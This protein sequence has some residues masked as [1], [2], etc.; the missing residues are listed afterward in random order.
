M[1][2][3]QDSFTRANANLPGITSDAWSWVDITST[4]SPGS[5]K[6]YSQMLARDPDQKTAV[7]YANKAFATNSQFF[8]FGSVGNFAV[9]TA[10]ANI[11]FRMN[12]DPA[13]SPTAYYHVTY[14]PKGSAAARLSVGK[15]GGDTITGQGIDL[16]FIA[17]DT[18]DLRATSVRVGA[19]QVLTVFVDGVQKLQLTDTTATLH[20]GKYFGIQSYANSA[21]E[22]ANG[23]SW[24]ADDF[25][26]G[27]TVAVGRYN[28]QQFDGT[29]AVPVSLEAIQDGTTKYTQSYVDYVVGE[30]DALYPNKYNAGYFN[31]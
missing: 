4:A 20:S 7:V 3:I 13:A 8:E 11:Q 24:E 29:N 21:R 28:M 25:K 27:D 10:T 23:N 18:F 26:A 2:R 19:T 15:V 17:T 6:I 30:P 1:T 14:V 9:G 16:S 12:F 31:S 22:N 5:F